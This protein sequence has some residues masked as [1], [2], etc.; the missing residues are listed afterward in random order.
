MSDAPAMMTRITPTPTYS[1]ASNGPM[2]PTIR[3]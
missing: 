1:K 2:A 3:S